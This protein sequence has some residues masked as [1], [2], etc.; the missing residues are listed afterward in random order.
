[1][2]KLAAM[3]ANKGKAIV[4][5]EPDLFEKET[6]YE[7]ATT[8]IA[9][10]TKDVIFPFTMINLRGGFWRFPGAA[11]DLPEDGVFDGGSGAGGSMFIY[12]SEYKIGFGYVTNAYVGFGGPDDRTIPLIKSVYEQ[13][14]KR[15]QQKATNK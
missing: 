2:A 12:N 13:V 14:K 10:T 4:P 7:E 8:F 3:M 15:K 6:T 9:D 1:M 5:G 11:M